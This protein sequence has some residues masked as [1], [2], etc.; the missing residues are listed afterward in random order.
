MKLQLLNGLK[1]VCCGAAFLLL[2]P[3]IV[4]YQ[5]LFSLRASDS[6]GLLQ[7]AAV[8]FAGFAGYLLSYL[9]RIREQKHPKQ[10]KLL[11]LGFALLLGM[12]TALL[13]G[14]DAWGVR[15]GFGLTVGIA[16]YIGAL[17][18]FERYSAILTQRRLT[19]FF[20]FSLAILFL[21]WILGRPCP[22]AWLALDFLLTLGVYLLAKNQGNIDY[23]MERRKHK[24]EFLPP[25]IRRYNSRLICLIL[26][27]VLI[28]FFLRGPLSRML[29]AGL[30]GLGAGLVALIKWLIALWGDQTEEAPPPAQQQPKPPMEEAAGGNPIWDLIFYLLAA[31]M[32]LWLIIRYRK[33][34]GKAIALFFYRLREFLHSLF[35]GRLVQRQRKQESEYYYD[36]EELLA[37]EALK[38]SRKTK[39]PR[40]AR[41]WKKQYRQFE[42]MPGGE[43]K[44]R[45]GYQLILNWLTLRELPVER[46]NTATEIYE[47]TREQV[48]APGYEDATSG[49]NQVRFGERPY[50]QENLESLCET[51]A[52]MG[53]EL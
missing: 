11:R 26:A 38:Q 18:Y 32:F 4:L 8:V 36:E 25:K 10:T 20:G 49:Y 42:G 1:Y 16:F 15:A 50:T 30:Q 3:L 2:Y 31:G 48:R 9:C 23:L 41:Q 52:A 46:W 33:Q 7:L 22:T 12:G 21:L 17:L 35:S 45:R 37:P 34:I 39:S 6:A 27:L 5:G 24:M 44:Y 43:E 19:L 47:R 53:R 14:W 40:S 28:G 13:F 29:T 51:L